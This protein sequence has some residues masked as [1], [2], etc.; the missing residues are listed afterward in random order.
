MAA[1]R[2]LDEQLAGLRCAAMADGFDGV[3]MTG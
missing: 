2:A 3:Q 1:I